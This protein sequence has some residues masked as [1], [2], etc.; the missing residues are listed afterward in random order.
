VKT[1]FFD[2][3]AASQLVSAAMFIAV[4]AYLWWDSTRKVE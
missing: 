3:D 4:C 1:P 2:S